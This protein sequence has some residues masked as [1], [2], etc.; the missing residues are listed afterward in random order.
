MPADL[1]FDGIIARRYTD[2]HQQLNAREPVV[3]LHDLSNINLKVDVPE[4][5]MLQAKKEGTARS[6]VAIFDAVSD[7]EYPLKLKE[8]STQADE[9]TKTYEVIFTMKSPKN[10]ILLPGMTARVRSEWLITEQSD[11]SYFLPVNVVLKDSKGNYVFV[12]NSV[13]EGKGEVARKSVTIGEISRFGI[14]VFSG[15]EQ[16]EH[17]ITAG[18]SKVFEGML[19]RFDGE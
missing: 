16:G 17:V 3:A 1:S 19:V 18:M 6:T 12:V 2:N 11:S 10:I 15:V 7:T 9:I 8:V 5:I 13:G 14:Q 4:S